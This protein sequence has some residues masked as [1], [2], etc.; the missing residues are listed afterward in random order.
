MKGI[1][2][3]SYHSSRT[4]ILETTYPR[5][6]P[7]KWAPYALFTLAVTM[8]IIVY[9]PSLYYNFQFDDYTNILKFFDI[10]HKSLS[11]LFFQHSRWISSWLNTVYYGLGKFNPFY[12]RLGNLVAHIVS[13]ILIFTIFYNLAK[14]S[15]S[16]AL[17]K[18][19]SAWWACLTAALFILHP[20][21]TQTVSYVIQG[22]L[23]GLAGL[24]ILGI[25]G[26]FLGYVYASRNFSKYSSLAALLIIALLACGTKEIAIVVP[27]LVLLTDWFFVAQGSYLDLKKRLWLHGLLMLLIGSTYIYFL[28]PTYFL[29]IFGLKMSVASNTGNLLT[30]SPQKKITVFYYAISQWK[31][32]VHYLG[33][34]F[35]P[36]NLSPDYD[37][38]LCR[39]VLAFDCIMPLLL[40]LI[41]VSY[42]FRRLFR[43]HTDIIGFGLL[44]FFI[45]VL[46]RASIIPSTELVV[47]YKTYI[48]SVGIFAL[49]A[50]AGIRLLAYCV[51]ARWSAYCFQAFAVVIVICLCYTTYYQNKVWQSAEAFWWHV[52]C[53]APKKARA[54]N[55]YGVALVEKERFS[56]AIVHFKKALELETDYPE[57]CNNLAI[58]YHGLGNLETAIMWLQKAILLQP[59]FAENYNNLA[60]FLI[61]KQDYKQAEEALRTALKLRPRY[62]KAYF[63][64]GRIYLE[65]NNPQEAYGYF[66]AACLQ[67]DFDNELGFCTYGSVCLMIGKFDEAISAYKKAISTDVQSFN[68]HAGLAQ[69]YV[70][71][72]E[73][74]KARELYELLVRQQ[75]HNLKIV[76]N[77]AEVLFLSGE[78]QKALQKYHQIAQ[79]P[80]ADPLAYLRIA[81]CLAK[82]GRGGE[83]IFYLEKLLASNAPS[84]LKRMAARAREEF[85]KGS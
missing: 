85:Q 74:S 48:A 52:I 65:F 73:Y 71:N 32:I 54:Y 7:K 20:V 2:A 76:M 49:I 23:E 75:P 17:L 31:V 4:A 14:R 36:F 40:L 42:I 69:A 77:L 10:R 12:Y 57:A 33:I 50:Y 9:I 51:H 19:Y 25:V 60:S 81:A 44:W 30:D 45:V 38:K 72:K 26:C 27:F 59:Y 16:H 37:W 35:W 3:T 78:Y 62:G 15:R 47:D 84:D 53:Q 39:H 24:C 82:L 18:E 29:E 8:G 80:Q 67:A 66:K 79:S 70:M 13:G 64:L 56:E 83:A 46:P 41:V 6:Q 58:A 21:Q 55:N 28:K 22:Q 5:Y 43:N 63:N 68:A 34:F 61:K 11:S 1:E